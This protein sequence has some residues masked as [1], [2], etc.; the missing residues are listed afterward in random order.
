M[1]YFFAKYDMIAQEELQN[2]EI[3]TFPTF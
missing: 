2:L 1:E 3:S